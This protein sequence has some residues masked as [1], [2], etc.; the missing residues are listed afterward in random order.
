[1]HRAVRITPSKGSGGADVSR[2]LA[3]A[4]PRERPSNLE[5][6]QQP[7]LSR[8]NR[9]IEVPQEPP[10]QRP[11]GPGQESSSRGFQLPAECPEQQ[12]SKPWQA[13]GRGKLDQG[14]RREKMEK[15]REKRRTEAKDV[16][17]NLETLRVRQAQTLVAPP[18]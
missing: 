3:A 17:G 15:S 7:P 6:S 13:K 12:T 14:S 4:E 9:G 18:A 5:S 8:E 10:A 2:I 16:S 11:S 1:M